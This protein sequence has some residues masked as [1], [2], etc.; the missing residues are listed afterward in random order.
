M[1]EVWRIS[2]AAGAGVAVGLLAAGALARLG[3]TEAVAAVV[4]LVAGG[5]LGWF[6]FDWKAGVAG[7]VGGLLGGVGAGGFARGALRRGGTAGGTGVL[8]GGAAVV[9]FL[10]ALIPIVGF[11]EAVAVPALAARARKRS[12]EKYAGLRTLAK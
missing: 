5:A 11:L 8:L 6:V 12:G 2:I 3:R 10:L 9:V 7:A 1:G 4:A